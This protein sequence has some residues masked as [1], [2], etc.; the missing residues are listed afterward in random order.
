MFLLGSS[1]VVRGSGGVRFAARG[2]GFGWG[3][4]CSFLGKKRVSSWA[5][6]RVSVKACTVCSPRVIA[7]YEATSVELFDFWLLTYYLGVPLRVRLSAHTARGIR[8]EGRYPLQS[9][10]RVCSRRLQA[11]SSEVWRLRTAG[12]NRE[13]I[14]MFNIDN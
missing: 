13:Y 11:Y 7:R 8:R 1:G 4:L 14:N 2:A 12:D 9:L 3:G 10:T 5:C 6:R